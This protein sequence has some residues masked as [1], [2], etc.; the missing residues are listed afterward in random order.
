MSL[1]VQ[2]T[3]TGGGTL[4]HYST[5]TDGQGWCIVPI[6]F[7][8][9]GN[10]TA[11]VWTPQNHVT[12]PVLSVNTWTHIA[13]TYSRARGL[14]LYVNGVS[15]GGTAEQINDAPG[16]PVILTL[17]NSI[18][19][20]GC[21]SQS[22]AT[23][24]FY[25]YLDEFHV[26]SREL[27]T[28]EVSALTKD[29]TCFDGLM[30]R[31]ETEID[32]GGSCLTCAV[33][34]NCTLTKDCDNVQCINNICANATC[35]DTIKNNGETDVDCGGSNCSPCGTG[36]ACSGAGD[37]VSKSC[38]SGI[39][40]RSSCNSSWSTTGITLFSSSTR[41]TCTRMF[42][43]SNDTLYGADK[44]R[45]YIWKLS[46]NAENATIVAGIYESAGSDSVKLH[47]PEDVYVDRY[48]SIYVV[49][50]NNHRIQKFINGTIHAKTIAGLTGSAGYSLNQLNY[51]RGF[52]FDPTDTFMYIAD[53]GCHRVVR[54]S[55]N[56]ISG[57]DGILVAGTG[58]PDNTIETL[59]GPWNIR[60]LSSI[61]NDLL[62]VNNDGHSVIRW[63]LDDTSGTFVA[64]LPGISCPN[65]VC[66]FKPADVRIDANLNMYVVDEK[67]H[68]VQ[69]FCENSDVG[70]TIFGNGVAGDSSTQLNSPRG[71]TFDSEMN[72]YVCDTGNKRVQKFLKL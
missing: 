18:T 44:D 25:G 64:G 20:K 31:D 3:S 11:T 19:G 4:V 37:C 32:C 50:T 43:D 5:Q 33:G 17:G 41:L 56:S 58:R 54:F 2:R 72:M 63:T 27:S 16:T 52:A 49:D 71:I 22:I 57:T 60:Y 21:N 26:Y 70:V 28:R 61:N 24:P 65:S 36:K 10:I 9:T 62:I 29:K 47:Y 51:P 7:S 23:G 38:A 1:W 68:R 45:H 40:K 67:N 6:G 35:N 55:T 34:K 8:S 39:C 15:V 48:G 42:I 14:T 30:N 59:N 69:M 12:G 46:K 66:L 53:R 13:T